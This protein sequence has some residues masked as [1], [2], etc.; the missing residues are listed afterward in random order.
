MRQ[1][2]YRDQPLTRATQADD[3]LVLSRK[4]SEEE[5]R[6][7]AITVEDFE[8]GLVEA[9][10]QARSEMTGKI[11]AA[12]ATQEAMIAQIS[13]LV[14]QLVE[15]KAVVPL[16]DVSIAAS[17]LV[18]LTVGERAFNNIACAGARV[19]DQIFLWHKSGPRAVPKTATVTE[20]GRISAVV[21]LPV[22]SAGGSPLVF[23]VTAIR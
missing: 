11:T 15:R 19:G 12:Q 13:A 8:A 4:V 9:V 18:T 5:K 21:D 10:N 16:P 3:V 7:V 22:I 23:G 2:R 14:S 1:A 20:N 17:S 6:S